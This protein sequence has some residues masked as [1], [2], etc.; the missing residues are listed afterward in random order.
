[1]HGGE[2]RGALVS[3]D[4]AGRADRLAV[5]RSSTAHVVELVGVSKRF[6]STQA[7][8]E[9]GFGLAPGEVVALVGENGAGKSTCV[10]L[11]A[12]VY[13]PDSGQVRLAGAPVTWSGPLEAQ[14]AGIAVVHQHPGLFPH[15]SVLENLFAG[16]LPRR[17]GVLD[18][19]GMRRRATEVLEQLGLS[20]SLDRAVGGLRTS[21]QQLVEI[22]R[23]LVGEAKVLI[24]DEPT[25]ALSL[26]EVERLFSVMA[27]L[28]EAGVALLFVGHRLE[29]IFA[30]S[31]RL[32]V[33]RDGALVEVRETAQTCVG[34]V[35]RLMVGRPLT[36]LYPR[37]GVSPGPVVLEA[38]GLS[39]AGVHRV[40]LRVQAG[41]IVG[42]A[43]LVGS[44][45]TELARLLFGVERSTAGQIRLA[46]EPVSWRSVAQAVRQGVAYVSEDRRGQSLIEDFSI[47]DNATLPIVSEGTRA[48][49]VSPGRLRALVAEPLERMRLRFAG[50]G[51]PV[52][53]LS[54]GNQQ[55][56]A[57]AKWLVNHPRLLILDE[58]TQGVDIQAKAEVHQI[59]AELAQQGLAVLL[60]SSD[61]PEVIGMSD[62]VLVMREGRVVGEF[63]R[64][65]S[66]EQ[67][68]EAA[69][70]GTTRVRAPA[71][72]AD[73]TTVG[74]GGR[75]GS[76]P[77]RFFGRA[78]RGRT[79][80]SASSGGAVSGPAGGRLARLRQTLGQREVGLLA[81]LVALVV[82]LTVI[83]PRFLTTTNLSAL[84]GDAALVGIVAVGQMLVVLTRNIDLSVASV[85]GLSA[86]LTGAYVKA[87]PG[88]SVLLAL[89]VALAVGIACGVVNGLA[90]AYGRVPS[91]VVT[92][93]TLYVY[94]GV[95]S[96]LANGQEIAPGDMPGWFLS[97]VSRP[98]LGL[99]ML[100]WV[101][102]LLFA[103]TDAVLRMTR[104]GREIYQSG[105]NPG[106][107]SLIGIPVARRTL[108][109]F[110]ISGALAG[111]DGALWAA[112]YG[113]VD[114]QSAF[115]LELTVIAAVVVGGVAL[116][117]GSGSITGVAL[118]AIT[119]FTIQ[120]ALRLARVDANAL[121]AFYGA[122]I[123]MA[124]STDALLARRSRRS[125]RSLRAAASNA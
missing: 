69:T 53:T 43:G 91:I 59:I 77:L 90:V 73:P 87:N 14:H 48:G 95:D 114:G 35:V 38:V 80:T 107:A 124:V 101:C 52:A 55:K 93:G 58:P 70:V 122:A 20:V 97:L 12:G 46:G 98:V 42:L 16:K 51:Q 64:G 15:L 123:I 44:G 21:E 33:L 13:R 54:G 104:W 65:A 18:R 79:G 99:S 23:A 106:G 6:G 82:P 41:E 112:H 120:N 26:G 39:G 72:T 56:V 32:V 47:L 25:A 121:L 76:L 62:R 29:E 78:T 105:S 66:Q 36:D 100:V 37:A 68:A 3:P 111:L 8:R 89:A 28:R 9:V 2:P 7:L 40:D 117:G 71:A 45:R 5:Q 27:G 30:V 125:R 75:P 109:A 118:G 81:S 50:Y 1:M 57:L 92:L 10:K 110:T 102:L 60:I 22:A 86:Y 11:L 119:L 85:I 17:H 74:T 108:A 84:A 94:R 4:D 115:G 103:V 19:A 88:T 83:N 61:L 49:L 67:I 63:P 31:D 24:L 116:R 113:I 96:L 34:D